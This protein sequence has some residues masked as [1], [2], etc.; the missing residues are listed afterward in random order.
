ML[1]GMTDGSRLNRAAS[2]EA[3]VESMEEEG[4]TTTLVGHNDCNKWLKASVAV[5]GPRGRLRA[6]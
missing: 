5:W 2:K 4:S 6:C 1:V 3:A